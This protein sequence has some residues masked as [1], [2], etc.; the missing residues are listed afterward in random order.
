MDESEP[1]TLQGCQADMKY[2]G[3]GSVP[4]ARPFH[5]HY[6]GLTLSVRVLRP[7]SDSLVFAAVELEGE[8][9]LSQPPGPF[10]QPCDNSG[11]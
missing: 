11:F 2:S 9:W 7:T 1:V 8:Q 3:C 10:L 4:S 5:I 6:Q